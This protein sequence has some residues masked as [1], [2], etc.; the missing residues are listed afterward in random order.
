MSQKVE[1]IELQKE[2]PKPAA[3]TP[4]EKLAE[5]LA[6]HNV[7]ISRT[8]EELYGPKTD[9]T[10]EEIQAEVDEFL[11]LREEWRKENRER[12]FDL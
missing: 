2:L 10:Q 8:P 9:Q 4:Q 1:E 5:Y 11:A 12:D 6:T 3:K 7:K